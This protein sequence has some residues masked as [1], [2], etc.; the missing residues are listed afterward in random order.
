METPPKN[1]EFTPEEKAKARS[2]AEMILAE[3]KAGKKN[4]P[5]GSPMSEEE[6]VEQFI[7]NNEERKLYEDTMTKIKA[8]F[9]AEAE[10]LLA[11]L[12]VDKDY[13][14]W[15]KEREQAWIDDYIKMKM[16]SWGKDMSKFYREASEHPGKVPWL[17][18]DKSDVRFSFNWDD[19]PPPPQGWGT[20]RARPSK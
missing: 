20:A 5:M 10:M 11:Q 18:W 12:K 14:R 4:F 6:Y 8:T 2:K 16:F 17:V 3:S 15:D 9:R 7:K 13:L 1:K 19:E